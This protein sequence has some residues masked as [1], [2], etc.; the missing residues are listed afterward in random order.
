[1][2]TSESPVT[3]KELPSKYGNFATYPREIFRDPLSINQIDR[4]FV[5]VGTVRYSTQSR[6]AKFNSPRSRIAP[7]NSIEAKLRIQFPVDK[8]EFRVELLR[9]W[10]L[11]VYRHHPERL[12]DN[13][14]TRALEF[15]HR[16]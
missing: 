3:W 9:I 13:G 10:W 15:L 11:L 5:P 2:H 16:G 4:D 12:Q 1:M 7:T 14:C 8:I 6:D